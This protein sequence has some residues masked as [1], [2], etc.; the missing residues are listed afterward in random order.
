MLKNLLI[1]IL[2]LNLGLQAKSLKLSRAQRTQDRVIK[3][4]NTELG[5]IQTRYASEFTQLALVE[6][7]KLSNTILACTKKT[8][9]FFAFNRYHNQILSDKRALKILEN[10]L[11]S[12]LKTNLELNLDLNQALIRINTIQTQIT[13]LEHFL[14]HDQNFIQAKNKYKNWPNFNWSTIIMTAVIA[15]CLV[16]AV[17]FCCAMFAMM[18]TSSLGLGG[19]II[20]GSTIIAVPVLLGSVLYYDATH[21]GESSMLSINF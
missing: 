9:W 16:P 14:L 21:I 1:T 17:I 4:V 20:V 13:Q 3:M 6:N 8:Y 18:S 15:V 11:E 2:M 7:S 5:R 19:S 12:A 10:K